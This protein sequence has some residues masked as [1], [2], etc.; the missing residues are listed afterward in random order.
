[1]QIHQD[2]Y[3]LFEQLFVRYDLIERILAAAAADFYSRDPDVHALGIEIH[4]GAASGGKDAAPVWIGS[5]EGGLHQA[6]N[7]RWCGDLIG[8]IIGR[9]TPDF[10]FDDALSAFAIVHNRKRQRFAN[11]V[12]RGENF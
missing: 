8:G 2:A 6:V 7:W 1:M 11:R 5:R 4:A 3:G 10:D 12:Q 9:R